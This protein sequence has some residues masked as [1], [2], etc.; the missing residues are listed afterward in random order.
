MI[1]QVCWSCQCGG[2]WRCGC[3][4]LLVLN[5]LFSKV[6]V[7]NR[8]FLPS[9]NYEVFSLVIVLQVSTIQ[10]LKQSVKSITSGPHVLEITGTFENPVLGSWLLW[11]VVSLISFSSQPFK[12][13]TSITFLFLYQ[14]SDS[15][16]KT[17]LDIEILQVVYVRLTYSWKS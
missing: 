16:R 17:L 4:V 11:L 14:R 9:A 13:L 7:L 10:F 6:F 3:T 12:D 2:L 5:W 1:V 15:K 8:A